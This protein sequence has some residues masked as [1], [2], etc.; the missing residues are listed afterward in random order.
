MAAMF[1][2][3]GL[4][5]M[6]CNAGARHD[7]RDK[8]DGFTPLMSAVAKNKLRATK[9]LLDHGADPEIEVRSSPLCF[10]RGAYK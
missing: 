1:G 2:T 9:V 7:L 5:K 10:E 6:L 8:W 4:V 3:P